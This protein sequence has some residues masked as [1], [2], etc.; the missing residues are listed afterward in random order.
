MLKKFFKFLSGYVIIE[1]YGKGAERFLNICLRRGIEVWNAKP[2]ENGIGLCVYRRDFFRLREV[3]GKSR[4]KVRIVKK[5]GL[6][7]KLRLYRKRYVFV[8]AVGV[9]AVITAVMSQ[10]IWLVEINGVKNSDINSVISTLDRLGIKSGALRH[11][12]PEGAD[13][14]RELI[15]DTDGIAW[16]W[17][18]IEGAKARVEIYEDLIPPDIIDKTVPCDIVAACDGVIKH[19]VVKNGNDVVKQ[20][21]AVRAGDVIVSGTVPVYKE[22]YPEEYI[23][24][25]SM[26]TVEAYT[27]YTKTGDYKTYCEHRIPTGKRKTRCSVEFMGKMFSLPLKEIPY[28]EYD[29]KETRHELYIPFFG[30]TGIAFDTVRYSE[31]EIVNEPISIETAVE[32]AKNDLEEKIASDLLFGSVLTDENLEYEQKDNETLKVTLKMDFIQNIASEK[33]LGDMNNKGEEVFDKQTD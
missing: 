7:Q 11:N 9:C 16:A 31:V 1:I 30:Y 4:V 6:T 2:I 24:V 17:V 22:G 19:M 26:A 14:K 21:D 20:G 10:F 28:E 8:I 5:Q 12:I 18:Y 33:P 27:S 15:N 32:F 29:V 23:Y 13:I 25:H 3:A